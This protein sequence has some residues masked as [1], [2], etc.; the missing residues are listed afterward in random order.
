M[1]FTIF[2]AFVVHGSLLWSGVSDAPILWQ[3][4]AA[5]CF[6]LWL[7]AKLLELTRAVEGAK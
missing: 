1:W 7:D 6:I 2:S 4:L 5:F 3:G